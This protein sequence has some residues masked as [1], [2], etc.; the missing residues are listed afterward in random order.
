M[1]FQK[2]FVVLEKGFVQVGPVKLVSAGVLVWLPAGNRWTTRLG[3]QGVDASSCKKQW[4]TYRVS[5][6]HSAM[7]EE[8]GGRVSTTEAY[9]KPA[10]CVQQWTVLQTM[11]RTV[12]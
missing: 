8:F 6:L 4:A 9:L 10:V 11:S 5:P 3:V 2:V 1:L 7:V 12:R